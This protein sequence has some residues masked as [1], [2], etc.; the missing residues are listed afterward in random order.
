MRWFTSRDLESL[1]KR[2]T[3]YKGPLVTWSLMD[4]WAKTVRSKLNAPGTRRDT[5]SSRVAAIVVYIPGT[6]YL[7]YNLSVL[8][9]QTL[10]AIDMGLSCNYQRNAY[11]I[12]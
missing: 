2:Y 4:E 8:P 5:S 6:W 10:Q 9:P 3:H 12:A 1:I 11:V 7:V